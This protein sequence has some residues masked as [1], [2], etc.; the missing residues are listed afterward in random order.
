M[1]NIF[2]ILFSIVGFTF[3][4]AQTITIDGKLILQ[5]EDDRNLVIEKTTIVLEQNGVKQ[6]TK[7]NERLAFSFKIN[8]SEKILITTV[9]KGIGS[10]AGRYY[11]L[12]N[13]ELKKTD[14]ISIKIPYALTCKYDKSK[15]NKTCPVC[16]TDNEVIPISYG[17][18][19]EIIKEG[20]EVKN[21]KKYK[22]G[23]CTTS[24]CDPNW[25]CKRDNLEF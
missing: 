21:E 10:I 19:A 7:V 24:D 17:L 5:N 11:T 15:E 12:K 20:E 4:S 25:Y 16:K 1:K 3:C 13:A 22:P 2:Y 14:T 8:D 6:V 9:S 18:T 23:G